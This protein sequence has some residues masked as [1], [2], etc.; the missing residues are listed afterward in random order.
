M[1][2]VVF[3]LIF[4]LSAFA[5]TAVAAEY[6]ISSLGVNVADLRLEFQANKAIIKVQNS[7]KVWIFP[8]INNLYEVEYDNQFLPNRYLRTIHQGE[9]RDSVLTLYEASRATMYQKSTKE[10]TSY[11]IASSTRDFFSFL[12]KLCSQKS[13]RGTY[14]LDGNGTRWQASVSAAETD[15]IKTALGRA[16]ARKHEITLKPL[17]QKKTPYIDMLTH[18]FLSEDT[19]MSIWI[20]EQG[21]PLKAQLKKKIWSMNWEIVS[22][23]K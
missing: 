7:G 9:L 4:L 17:S 12:S 1:R 23:H 18:N 6:K 19:R 11:Q 16:S 10:N 22:I 5:L 14:L 21:L 20:S 2:K 13:T 8:H 15:E 3:C